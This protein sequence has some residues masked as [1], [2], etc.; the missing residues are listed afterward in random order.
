[1]KRPVLKEWIKTHDPTTY[2]LEETHFRSIDTNTLKVKGWGGR[3]EMAR[4][5]SAKIDFKP[6]KFTNKDIMY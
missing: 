2:G 3:A 4:L 5:I 1:M 6:K